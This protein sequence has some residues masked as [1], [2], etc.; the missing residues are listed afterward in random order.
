MN[1]PRG[2]KKYLT[3]SDL[4]AYIGISA[5]NVQEI[6]HFIDLSEKFLTIKINT[7]LKT[8]VELLSNLV[9]P[10][11]FSFFYKKKTSHAKCHSMHVN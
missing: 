1:F 7:L 10:I 8:K 11:F 4:I 2:G 5:A 9:S 6:I 3:K